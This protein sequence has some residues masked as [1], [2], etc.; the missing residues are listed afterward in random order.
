MFIDDIDVAKFKKD[1]V[2]I[3]R[4]FSEQQVE[5]LKNA[6]YNSFIPEYVKKE[7]KM[8]NIQ[9]LQPRNRVDTLQEVAANKDILD[10]CSKLLEGGEPIIGGA[11]LFYGEKGIEYVQGWHRDLLHVPEDE[12]DNF[13]FTKEYNHNNVQI[14]IALNHDENLWF[15]RGSHNRQFTEE[16]KKVFGDSKVMADVAY[17]DLPNAEKVILKP[18]EAAF[19]NN[20]ALH[21]GYGGTLKS[22]RMVVHLGYHSNKYSPTF[23]FCVINHHEFSTKYLNSLST[24]VRKLLNDHIVEKEQHPE[25]ERFYQLHQQF[26]NSTF[27]TKEK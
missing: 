26:I 2:V 6:V 22:D 23:N 7:K 12:I 20:N 3:K 21:K 9:F 17:K 19:Y 4:L 18:G 1:G 5:Q 14:N 8:A 27:E 11:S 10:A 25:V 15:I 24:S 16:E 13:W